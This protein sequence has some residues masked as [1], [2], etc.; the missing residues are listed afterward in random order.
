MPRE[1]AQLAIDKYR[2]SAKASESQ[3]L[4]HD[5]GTWKRI[6][7]SKQVYE[8]NFPGIHK[9][10]MT[11]TPALIAIM[12][13]EKSWMR[14]DADLMLTHRRESHPLQRRGHL[15]QPLSATK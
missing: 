10:L 6:V 8:H 7:A 4:W 14:T 15:W 11:K 13:I 12:P 5:V 9:Q 3:L 1:P 2:E